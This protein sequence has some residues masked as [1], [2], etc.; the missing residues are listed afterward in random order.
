MLLR[1]KPSAHWKIEN[2]ALPI[3]ERQWHSLG[4]SKYHV[5]VDILSV[6]E[7]L[8]RKPMSKQPTSQPTNL[9]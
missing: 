5:N 2:N 1:L 6:V 9:E 4:P 8:S 7:C 3:W